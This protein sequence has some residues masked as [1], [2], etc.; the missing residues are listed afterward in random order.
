MFVF[1]EEGRLLCGV[2][3]VFFA[4]IIVLLWL[5]L[6]QSQAQAFSAH[7]GQVD[8]S[9]FPVIRLYLDI[10]DAADRP[11]EGVQRTD[12]K[13]F[14]DGKLVQINNFADPR[15][16]RPLTTM[17]ILDRS[18]S[19]GEGGKMDALKAAASRYVRFMKEVDTIGI[20]IFSDSTQEVQ[21]LTSRKNLLYEAVKSMQPGGGT[22]V[23]DAV[24]AGVQAV[25]SVEG[26]KV[27]LAI[28]DGMDNESWKSSE[29]VVK[30]ARRYGVPVYTIGL[31][32]R[33][34][35]R[36]DDSGISEE[37]LRFLA[38]ET[39][40]LYFYA[41]SSGELVGVYELLSSRFQAGYELTYVSPQN[42]ED[43]TTRTVSIEV[44]S[45]SG[46]A[47]AL[48]SY[49][50]PGVIIPSADTVLFLCLLLPLVLLAFAPTILRRLGPV[51]NLYRLSWRR[52]VRDICQLPGRSE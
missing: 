28:T 49:Y 17:L 27:I 25:R 1:L 15:T 23:Y 37:G 5:G 51:R 19:M 26:K 21:S 41:P 42:R 36:E 29:G 48:N 12:F 16:P 4:L 30:L 20:V 43:G 31:G 39:G 22:A 33:A 13:V 45:G 11:V 52:R 7:L 46:S 18:G 47:E 24:H 8:K 6:S 32:S 2:G 40:G 38:T 35:G 14:E 50:V 3:K 34:T 10:V 9:D 44:E